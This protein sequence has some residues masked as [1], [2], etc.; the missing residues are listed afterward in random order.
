MVSNKTRRGSH[1]NY[2]F[3]FNKVLKYGIKN[4]LKYGP[5][6]AKTYLEYTS[7]KNGP[8]SYGGVTTQH[9]VQRQYRRKSMPKRKRKQWKR[10]VKKVR[11][12][13]LKDRG[14]ISAT[15]N[16]NRAYENF[17]GLQTWGELHLYSSYGAAG[18]TTQDLRL[19]LGDNMLTFA[20]KYDF[21][22][23]GVADG[24]VPHL[25]EDDVEQ[26]RKKV[27]FQSGVL[28][29]TFTNHPPTEGTHTVI[30][31]DVY[32][33]V[34]S[35]FKKRRGG[36][37]LVNALAEGLSSQ[38]QVPQLNSR[39]GLLAY[40][41][42]PSIQDRGVSVFECG[43][44]L[45]LAGAKIIRKT[46]YIISQNQSITYQIRDPKNHSYNPNYEDSGSFAIPG[47]TRTVL[48]CAK[49]TETNGAVNVVAKATRN[50]KFTIEGVA[51]KHSMYV[52]EVTA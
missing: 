52:T 33:V 16:Y 14:L 43:V 31:M 13:E 27:L 4:A 20:T 38:N 47:M 3:N 26:E 12:V 41:D 32:E 25:M 30:E 45:A 9:D 29:V 10:F 40:Y 1:S 35:K 36:T 23:S 37:T 5:G 28:D 8:R 7:K 51:D 18:Y 34:Y 6:I 48:F 2:G 17:N 22:S 42:K 19:V 44:G 46:K 15:V 24:A 39:V 49:S 21:V 11:A 50:Y